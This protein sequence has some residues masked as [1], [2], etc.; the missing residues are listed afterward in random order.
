MLYDRRQNHVYASLEQIAKLVQRSHHGSPLGES[1][2]L[3]AQDLGMR[4]DDEFVQANITLR[5]AEDRFTSAP[6]IGVTCYADDAFG[7]RRLYC[8]AINGD[9]VT[10]SERS[11]NSFE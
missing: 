9:E 4:A 5:G 11:F 10:R 7:R 2:R 6:E 8:L 3:R 1:R